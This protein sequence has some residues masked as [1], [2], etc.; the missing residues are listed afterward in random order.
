M[1]KKRRRACEEPVQEAVADGT[2]FPGA[3]VCLDIQNGSGTYFPNP[4]VVGY[5][6]RPTLEEKHLL[7][8]RY[9][10]VLPEA[11]ATMNRPSANCMVMY[12]A[13]FTYSVRF[14]LHPVMVDILNKYNL[15]SVQI[16]PTSWHNTCSFTVT[17]EPHGL[18]YI[19]CAIEQVH[20]I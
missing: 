14:S 9:R 11:D 5:L 18:T 4:K 2:G 16:V 15:A 10:F 8:A 19:D 3:P 7:L 1:L 12:R 17:C 20:S 6:K 13:A